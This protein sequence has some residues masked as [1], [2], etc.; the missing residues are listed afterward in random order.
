MGENFLPISFLQG[1]SPY[2]FQLD[3]SA[4]ETTV[5]LSDGHTGQSLL[6]IT[7]AICPS[8]GLAPGKC[9]F[10]ASETVYLLLKVSCSFHLS[11]CLCLFLFFYFCLV[12]F[13]RAAPEAYGS[14][15]A[16]GLIGAVAA[17]LHQSH[18]NAGSQPCLQ[19]TPQLMATLDP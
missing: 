6:T 4:K 18:S 13:S 7:L 12:A 14:S 17:G 19:P 2:Q 9:L 15:Q 1:T 3:L 5:T 8:F 11:L 16:R 10:I